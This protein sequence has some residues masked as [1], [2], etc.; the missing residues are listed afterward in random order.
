MLS[1]SRRAFGILA[2]LLLLAA[3]VFAGILIWQH[4]LIAPWTR[5]GTVEAYVVN[6]APED[7][8]RVVKLSV[9]DNDPVHIGDVLYTIDPLDFQ[10]A[11]ASAEA[12]LAARK[13]DMDSKVR[14]AERRDSLTTLSTSKEEQQTYQAGADMAR[15]AYAGAVA[16]LNQSR[17]D[18]E[19]TQVRSPV[20]GYVTN[21]QLRVGDYATKG[22]RNI[23]LVDT[24]S[25]WISGNFEET[26]LARI[27]PGDQAVAQLLGFEDPVYG[28]VDSIARGINTPNSAPGSLGLASVNP[29]FTWVRLAQRI[30][31]RVHIDRVPPTVQLSVGLTATVS[32]G[33]DAHA[34][35]LH[36]WL[37][38][39]LTMGGG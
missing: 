23:A 37:S 19:R 11:I 14:Q 25:F 4:Y 38:R 29:V 1:A 30:P 39:M 35:S 10:I 16:Q 33:K 18:L 9:R 28:H 5:D 26:K 13:A 31:V 12:T 20:N 27:K 22:T 6:L 2:T 32:V 15:A 36:G 3:S 7:S 24:D 21:L 34:G 17:I 8:G